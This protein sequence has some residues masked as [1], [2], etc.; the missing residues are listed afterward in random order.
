ML[1][2]ELV[3]DP[4]VFILYNASFTWNDAVYQENAETY[5]AIADTIFAD[6]DE[7]TMTELNGQVDLDDED[8]PDVARD[9]LE[10]IGLL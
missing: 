3:E 9:Y 6:L 1:D 7:A 8:P 10:E 2:L 4:G 5:D